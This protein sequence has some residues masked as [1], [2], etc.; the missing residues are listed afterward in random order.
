MANRKENLQRAGSFRVAL[1]VD[2]EVALQRSKSC[3][4][5]LET[6]GGERV[7]ARGFYEKPTLRFAELVK[8]SSIP[9]VN[10][11]DE[12]DEEPGESNTTQSIRRIGG[13]DAGTLSNESGGVEKDVSMPKS[14]TSPETGTKIEGV[15]P[16]EE[17]G[18]IS[19]LST[20]NETTNAPKDT[21]FHKATSRSKYTGFLMGNTGRLAHNLIFNAGDEKVLKKMVKPLIKTLDPINKKRRLEDFRYGLRC[22]II[23]GEDP[24]LGRKL[25][26]GLSD[27]MT[28]AGIDSPHGNLLKENFEKTMRDGTKE[29]TERWE[30]MK[31]QSKQTHIPS[32]SLRIS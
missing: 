3:P 23:D 8:V 28:S 24:E 22:L 7:V 12:P 31:A 26:T 2:A 25:T 9:E 11:E 30:R 27:V 5:T 10:R 18:A 20:S 32:K 1:T 15:P 19:E 4:P 29:Q 16:Y 13:P 6:S 14:L 21:I 17:E